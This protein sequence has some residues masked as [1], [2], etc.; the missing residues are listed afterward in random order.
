MTTDYIYPILDIVGPE[1]SYIMSG[2][3]YLFKKLVNKCLDMDKAFHTY[4]S[5]IGKIFVMNC[6]EFKILFI[7][8][9]QLRTPSSYFCIQIKVS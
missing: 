6:Y 8:Y 7:N 3:T 1:Y 5:G 2:G 4:F 9:I